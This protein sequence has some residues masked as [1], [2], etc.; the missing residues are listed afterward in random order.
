[1]LIPCVENADTFG[2]HHMYLR[3]SAYFSFIYYFKK[4]NF[5][6]LFGEGLTLSGLKIYIQFSN[7]KPPSQSSKILIY[8][9]I[10]ISDNV[11]KYYI[12][13]IYICMFIY[14]YT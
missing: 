5:R 13:K 7:A 9:N 3:I 8:I 6:S 1:M 11:V 10:S 12:I 2:I 14:I 4:W